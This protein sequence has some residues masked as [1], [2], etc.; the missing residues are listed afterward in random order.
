MLSPLSKIIN[1]ESN[2]QIKQVKDP[3]SYRVKGLLINKTKPITLYDS[4]LIFRDTDK[5]FELIRELL[6][7][8]TNKKY[9]NDLANKLL[10]E[11]LL[12]E[13]AKE[14]YFDEKL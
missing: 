5:K 4:L 3:D 12:I 11:K 9:N 10:D 13:F 7:M 6:K 1:L 14:I 8:I 2:S